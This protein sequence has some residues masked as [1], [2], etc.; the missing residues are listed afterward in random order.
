MRRNRNRR[1][2]NVNRPPACPCGAL[3]EHKGALCRKCGRRLRW[4]KRANGMRR[5]QA[6]QFN[7]PTNFSAGW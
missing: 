5:G 7:R 1:R 6:K 3:S 2:P 4:I